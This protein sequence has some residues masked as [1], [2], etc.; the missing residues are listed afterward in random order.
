MFKILLATKNKG[1]VKEIRSIFSDS[2][3]KLIELSREDIDEVNENGKNYFENALKKAK[4]Y[5]EKY[6]LPTLADDSG[7]EIDALDGAPGINSARFVSKEATFNEKISKILELMQDVDRR[8]AC[9]R[10][11]FVLYLPKERKYFSTKGVVE[12]EILSEPHKKERS[13]FGYDPIFKPKGFDKSFSMLGTDIKNR[14]SHRSKA[15]KKMKKIIAKQ[16]LGGG[17]MVEIKVNGKRLPANKY[18]YKVF[19]SVILAL[20]DTLKDVPEIKKVEITI[21]K[22]KDDKSTLSL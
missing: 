13:G 19:E 22:E 1:K 7:L 16:F 21:D 17:E 14:I 6:N 4:H 20:L 11:T 9:F 10:A 2:P 5:A 15:L 8:S 18:V 3:V 12:G